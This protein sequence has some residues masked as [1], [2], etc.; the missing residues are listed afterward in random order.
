[1][2]SARS[3]AR[4]RLDTGVATGSDRAPMR[5]RAL[6]ASVAALTLALGAAPAFGAGSITT[7][8]GPGVAGSSGDGGPATQAYIPTPVGV[9]G[10]ADGSYL[11]AHQGNPS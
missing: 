4:S 2:A 11:I 10:L 8:V 5:Q 7:V 9:T 3:A 1:M 6:I